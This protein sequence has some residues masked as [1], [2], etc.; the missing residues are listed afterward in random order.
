[1][2]IKQELNRI[3]GYDSHEQFKKLEVLLR[4]VFK[5]GAAQQ[6]SKC[7][8]AIAE[9]HSWQKVVETDVPIFD[10]TAEISHVD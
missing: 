3:V 1:M 9:A 4:Q 6:L 5:L 2:T 8:E 10:I 7:S